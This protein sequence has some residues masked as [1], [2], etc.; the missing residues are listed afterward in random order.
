MFENLGEDVQEILLEC[1]KIQEELH[2]DYIGTEVLL[3]AL[4][5]YPNSICNFLFNEY[6]ITENMI[7]NI[8]NKCIFLRK[9]EIYENKYTKIYRNNSFK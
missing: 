2:L 9:Y 7:K 8:I 4:Y 6:L 3:L 1:Q 5:N